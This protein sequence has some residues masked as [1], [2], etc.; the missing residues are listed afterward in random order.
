MEDLWRVQDSGVDLDVFTDQTQYK[1][2]LKRFSNTEEHDKHEKSPY[3]G[4][5]PMKSKNSV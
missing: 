5:S 2:F 1:Q 3:C 4:K